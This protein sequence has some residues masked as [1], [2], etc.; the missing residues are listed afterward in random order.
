MPLVK[1]MNVNDNSITIRGAYK[2]VFFFYIYPIYHISQYYHLYTLY[3]SMLY[4]NIISI[5]WETLTFVN[6]QTDNYISSSEESSNT[7][8][9]FLFADIWKKTYTNIKRYHQLIRQRAKK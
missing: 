4:I 5:F 7:V 2:Y 3:I 9:S 8:S 6:D 1:K